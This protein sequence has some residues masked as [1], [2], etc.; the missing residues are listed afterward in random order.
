M[1]RAY[2]VHSYEVCGH[3][4]D[5]RAVVAAGHRAPPHQRGWGWR[6]NDER[7]A[8]LMLLT[9]KLYQSDA[10]ASMRDALNV[11]LRTKRW[12]I[13]KEPFDPRAFDAMEIARPN[14]RVRESRRKQEQLISRHGEPR[15]PANVPAPTRVRK[16]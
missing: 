13:A 14:R 3:F 4:V 10:R 12:L 16:R 11:D 7:G 8:V 5:T 9:Q 6:R 2:T 15:S 1:R